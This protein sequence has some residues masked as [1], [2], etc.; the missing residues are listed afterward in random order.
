MSSFQNV[1]DLHF[2]SFSQG[3]ISEEKLVLLLEKYTSQNP[4]F[5]YNQYNHFNLNNA[6]EV[7]CKYEFRV[8]K[9]QIPEL[10]EMLQLP[11]VF[12]C[13]QRTIASKLEGLCMLLKRTAYPCRYNDTVHRFG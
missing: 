9:R 8:E 13:N 1:R 7:E 5:L 2:I 10:A 6:D 11:E 4:A 12:R 3:Y